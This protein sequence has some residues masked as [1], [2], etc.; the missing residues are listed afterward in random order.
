VCAVVVQVVAGARDEKGIAPQALRERA[1]Q[2]ELAT[3]YRFVVDLRVN[4]HIRSHVH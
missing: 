4:L 1:E 3:V 2:H